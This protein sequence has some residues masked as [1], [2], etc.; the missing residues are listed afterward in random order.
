MPAETV[1]P[2]CSGIAGAAAPAFT[3]A[4][5]LGRRLR[6]PRQ[7]RAAPAGPSYFGGAVRC[8]GARRRLR[9]GWRGALRDGRRRDHR[10]HGG[11]DLGGH[12]R[13]AGCCGRGAAHRGFRVRIG[14][15]CPPRP[16][17]SL[18]APATMVQPSIQRGP[19]AERPWFTTLAE[20]TPPG[21]AAFGHRYAHGQRGRHVHLGRGHA[22]A[23]AGSQ[24]WQ[25][26][27]FPGG[28]SISRISFGHL[29]GCWATRWEAITR[30]TPSWRRSGRRACPSS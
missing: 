24:P 12:G 16:R 3:R 8:G 14:I 29:C 30:R 7:A 23:R 28:T 6:L 11:P 17:T 26:H 1:V 4:S 5:A 18:T 27:A 2:P 21:P 13:R 15:A 9:V 10:R 19:P 25:H 20:A 22:C